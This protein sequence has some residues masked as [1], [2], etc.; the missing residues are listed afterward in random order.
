MHLAEIHESNLHK[1]TIRNDT[2]N[3]F[4]LLIDFNSKVLASYWVNYLTHRLLKIFVRNFAVF[5]A[6]EL[7]KDQLQLLFRGNFYLPVLWVVRYF[8]LCYGSFLLVWE[9]F[10]CI[11]K[12]LPLIFYLFDKLVVYF[13]GLEHFFQESC[14]LCVLKLNIDVW[15][16][17][18]VKTILKMNAVSHPFAKFWVIHETTLPCG[19]VFEKFL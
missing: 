6:V 15:I 13:V 2:A 17:S 5:V 4:L 12:C 7:V 11:F 8:L 18:K 10:V 19:E 1:R 3:H 9:I 14:S 16:V